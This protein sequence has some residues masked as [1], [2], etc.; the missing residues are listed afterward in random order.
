MS[1]I[2]YKHKLK[3]HVPAGNLECLE[4]AVDC[5][6]DAVYFGFNTPSNL[7]NFKGINFSYADARQGVEYA[8]KAGKRVLITVN[9]YPQTSELPFCYE[10]IDKAADMQ[11]D[12]VVLSDLG[13]LAYTRQKH[14]ELAIY[15]SVQAGACHLEA[16]DFFASEFG[17]DCV[18]LP[19]VLTLEEIRHLS[20]NT[21]VE[22]EAFAF[23]SLCINY[24]GKCHL[25]SYITG[26]STNTIGTCSTPRFLSFDQAE[27]IIA[28]I[29]G[30]AINSFSYNEILKDSGPSGNLPE[31][32][33]S[34]WGNHFLINRRQLCKARYSLNGGL[35]FQLNNFVYLNVLDILPELIKAGIGALK[36][37]GRQRNA[38]YVR[39]T[40]SIFREAIDLYYR[41]PQ[42]YKGRAAWECPCQRQFPEIEPST[43]CY[44][45]K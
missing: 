37:E 3:L 10:A 9:N 38:S 24:E 36:I 35:D 40:T 16:I 34:Q 1:T 31:E 30:K 26:E 15:L 14:P 17:V 8:H 18:I 11:A 29:N 2:D 42:G 13:L 43:A 19:R 12:G 22:L 25:S 32:E 33:L 45:G 6:A 27:R 5:G 41:S 21:D 4:V 39:D 20:A 44:L 7:R 28:R 23:G